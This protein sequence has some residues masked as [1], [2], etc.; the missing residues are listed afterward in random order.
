ML[1]TPGILGPGAIV[2]GV[3][4]TLR[5]FMNGFRIYANHR[6]CVSLP[7]GGYVATEAEAARIL[8]KYKPVVVANRA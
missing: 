7:Y 3:S 6:P 5:P 4:V 2:N 1:L 8:A